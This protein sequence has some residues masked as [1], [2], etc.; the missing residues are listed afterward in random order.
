MGFKEKL[1]EHLKD[2]LSEEELSVLPRGFQTLGKIIILKLNPKLNEKKKEIFS[3][4]TI[5][6]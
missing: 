3:F 4:Y 5:Q 6:Y 1:K 2:K